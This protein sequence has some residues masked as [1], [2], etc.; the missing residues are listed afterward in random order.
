MAL[1]GFEGGLGGSVFAGCATD[2]GE[3]TG[4]AAFGGQAVMTRGDHPSG[5]DRLAEAA[6]L[7]GLAPDDLVV[8]IQGD[9][10]LF[11]VDLIGQLTALLK[12]DPEAVMVT[13]ARKISDPEVAADPN[14]VK[15]V[16]DARGY[17]LYFSR[18][19]IPFDRDRGLIPAGRFCEVRY[20]DLV[21]DPVRVVEG[22]YEKLRLGNLEPVRAKLEP[23]VHSQRSF[24]T[25]QHELAPEVSAEV[26]CRWRR[27][28]ET[29]GYA[30]SGAPYAS[31]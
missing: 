25:N 5:S 23:Y 31:R 6:R 28:A 22:I 21:A 9:Q 14:V 20:E 19:V 29:Y 17:A 3:G 30:G 10:P 7:L 1:S 24:Q 16:C 11:P 18:A 26:L 13:P 8:N 12:R 15:V 4:V 2:S 27:Y